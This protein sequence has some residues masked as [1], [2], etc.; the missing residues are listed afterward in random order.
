MWVD[1]IG[2]AKKIIIKGVLQFFCLFPIEKNKITLLNELSFTYGDSMKYID[3]YIH[4]HRKGKYKI[5]FPIKKGAILSEY[6]DDMVVIPNTYQY[7]KELIARIDADAN[8]GNIVTLIHMKGS[9]KQED[10]PLMIQMEES[11]DVVTEQ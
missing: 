4:E 10:V 9:I 5:V 3:R 2:Y 1:F 7:F 8:V 11:S 6:P